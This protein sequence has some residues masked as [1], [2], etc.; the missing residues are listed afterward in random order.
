MGELEVNY[1]EVPSVQE[2]AKKKLVTIP[3]R[4]VRDDH[5][6]SSIASNDRNNKEVPVIDMQRLVNSNDHD[7][8]NLE[9]NKLHFAAQHWGFFQLINHGVSS[10][11][12]EK[13]K[14][15]TQK[16]YDL[17]L[18]EKKKFERSPRDA[19]GFGQLFVVSDEQKL[20]WADLFY[21]KTAPPHLRMP[22][23]SKLYLS[24]R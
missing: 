11:V 5:D 17:P 3:S 23:F 1:K 13:M 8:M 22:I 2:L 24:L 20:D 15:E 18:E 4:Y 6:N 7:I 19:D 12:V 16:F 14:H 9:L 21:L 10:S